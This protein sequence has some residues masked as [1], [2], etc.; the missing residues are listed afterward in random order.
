MGLWAIVLFL[1][2]VTSPLGT[3]LH[4]TTADRQLALVKEAIHTLQPRL[5]EED[6][7]RFASAIHKASKRYGVDALLLVAIAQQ[8]SSFRVG[9]PEGRAGEYGICQIQKIW[10]RDKAFKEHFTDASIETL[11]CPE[12]SVLYAAWILSQL[13]TRRVTRHNIPWWTYYNAFTMK[14]RAK[15]HHRVGSKLKK[16]AH[17]YGQPPKFAYVPAPKKNRQIAKPQPKV[18]V[19]KIKSAMNSVESGKEGI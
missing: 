5:K 15:Y 3:S 18:Q 1:G 2:H 6:N 10:L 17:L 7:Q 11:K 9:L 14:N 4:S 13:R 8:E 19:K 16:I 12:K